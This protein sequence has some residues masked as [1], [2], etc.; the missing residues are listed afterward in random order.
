MPIS[1]GNPEQVA[2]EIADLLEARRIPYALGGALAYNRYGAARGTADVDFNVFLPPE[3]AAEVL[4]MLKGEGLEIDVEAHAARA[5]D[6]RHAVGLVSGMHVDLF[7]NSIPLHEIAATRV[8][9]H[10]VL[11]RPMF[12][13]SAEDLVLLKLLFFRGKDKL[14]IERLVQLRGEKLDR[15]YVRDQLVDMMG[16]DDERV[17]VW[18]R[19]CRE[20]PG[21]PG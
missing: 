9:T 18:D 16:E 8:Q 12:V 2:R 14:D 1:P 17:R 20:L 13:L 4:S 21:T 19:Y 7:F 5:L 10:P 11:G 6:G 15:E 3:R